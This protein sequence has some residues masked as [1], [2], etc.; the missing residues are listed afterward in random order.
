MVAEAD[1]ARARTREGMA[2]AKAKGRLRGKQ[3]KLKP[4]QEKHLVELY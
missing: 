1:L 2:V 4:A 3:A